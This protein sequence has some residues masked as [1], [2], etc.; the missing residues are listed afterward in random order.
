MELEIRNNLFLALSC[1]HASCGIPFK[2]AL[3]PMT[4]AIFLAS[5]F[6]RVKADAA[7]FHFTH[8]ILLQPDAV[9][10]VLKHLKPGARVVAS[11][12]KWAGAWAVPVNM[13]VWL[14]AKRST[15]SLQGLQEPWRGLVEQI[16]PMQVEAMWGNG[17]FVASGTVAG[18]A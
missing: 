10:N 13:L 2:P 15:T 18:K 12:L 7:L 4:H 8:D 1:F 17:I 14:G 16:G 3:S 11:G 6:A 5:S 9:A